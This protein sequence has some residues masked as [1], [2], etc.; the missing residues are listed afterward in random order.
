MEQVFINLFTNA[1]ESMERGGTLRI[2][3]RHSP[4]SQRTTSPSSPTGGSGGAAT[5]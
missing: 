1:A 4:E 2:A 3:T 5:A